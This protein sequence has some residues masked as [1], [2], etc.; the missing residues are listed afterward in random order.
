M[1]LDV[2]GALYARQQMFLVTPT[3]CMLTNHQ[4]GP[5]AW[6]DTLHTRPSETNAFDFVQKYGVVTEVQKYVFF[7]N[8]FENR[9]YRLKISSSGSELRCASFCINKYL[10]NH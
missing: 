2:D 5:E 9:D 10:E 8:R 1:E 3:I 6:P 4:G 7:T